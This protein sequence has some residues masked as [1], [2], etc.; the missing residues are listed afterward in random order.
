MT[1]FTKKQKNNG[2]AS[3]RI[4]SHVTLAKISNFDFEI[5]ENTAFKKNNE[6][7]CL[8]FNPEENDGFSG[9]IH[10]EIN[11]RT[12]SFEQVSIYSCVDLENLDYEN[13]NIEC[14]SSLNDFTSKNSEGVKYLLDFI[15]KILIKDE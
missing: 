7:F 11:P 14:N 4:L 1:V 9:Y 8:A 5:V 13:P 10:Y 12:D 2:K 6:R 15:D 3:D